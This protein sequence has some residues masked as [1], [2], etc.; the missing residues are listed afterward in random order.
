MIVIGIFVV[1]IAVLIAILAFLAVDTWKQADPVKVEA[2]NEIVRE[3]HER[4]VA[5][6][7]DKYGEVEG[8]RRFHRAFEKGRWKKT[9]DGTRISMAH[10]ALTK[11]K[12][13]NGWK[14]GN[15]PMSALLTWL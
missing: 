8:K 1:S 10:G 3:R 13:L 7:V 15:F 14:V 11:G 5:A 12:L 6:F 9:L 2:E 4:R